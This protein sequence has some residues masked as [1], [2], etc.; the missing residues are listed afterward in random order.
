MGC[1]HSGDGGGGT[2]VDEGEEAVEPIDGSSSSTKPPM[3]LCPAND[4]CSELG[5]GLK[6]CKRHALEL[7]PYYARGAVE[8]PTTKLSHQRDET[9]H[10]QHEHEPSGGGGFGCDPEE[11]AKRRTAC[12]ETFGHSCF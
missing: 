12:H 7:E 8:N 10:P 6:R 9:R 1:G 2:I 4:I 5:G 3:V 11:M